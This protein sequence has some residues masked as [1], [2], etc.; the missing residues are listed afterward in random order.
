MYPLLQ[1]LKQHIQIVGD[2]EL[3]HFFSLFRK[4]KISAHVRSEDLTCLIPESILSP[5]LKGMAEKSFFFIY[6]QTYFIKDIPKCINI[7]DIQFREK[8]FFICG[9][10][11]SIFIRKVAIKGS[12]AD[13]SFITDITD[14]NIRK[15]TFSH[16]LYHASDQ[17]CSSCV[18]THSCF[19]NCVQVFFRL[20]INILI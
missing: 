19:L 11:N 8:T 16:Q 3:P 4:W 10:Q 13:I 12:S 9:F 1:Q 6:L 2:K 20:V 18:F 15:V 7:I 14:R 5:H 17:N